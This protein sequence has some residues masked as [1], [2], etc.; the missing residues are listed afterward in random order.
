MTTGLK[1]AALAALTTTGLL[2][3]TA[4]VR[5]LGGPAP[6]PPSRLEAPPGAVAGPARAATPLGG[7]TRLNVT[8]RDGSFTATGAGM[9][10]RAIG[11]E[12]V[13]VYEG[14]T[15][16]Q[17]IVRLTVPTLRLGT[18]QVWHDRAG[19]RTASPPTMVEAA[20]GTVI[21]ALFLPP[22][23]QAELERMQGPEVRIEDVSLSELGRRAQQLKRAWQDAAARGDTVEQERL[24]R[25]IQAFLDGTGGGE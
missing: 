25:L 22:F 6:W 17:G 19:W 23:T 21:G 2:G 11:A 13:Y 8:L 15:D 24:G 20:D 10:V 1:L 3:C 9:R 18:W 16:S 12:G 7:L 4:G 5:S 14:V